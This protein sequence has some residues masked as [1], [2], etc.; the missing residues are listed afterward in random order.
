[1]G[2]RSGRRFRPIHE[3]ASSKRTEIT[4]LREKAEHEK[5][6]DPKDP[7][8]AA[9]VLLRYQSNNP[10]YLDF[11]KRVEGVVTDALRDDLR[12]K[13][14]LNKEQALSLVTPVVVENKGLSTISRRW[15]TWGYGQPELVTITEAGRAL[16][17]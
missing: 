9:L 4:K 7:G 12:M 17:A 13:N 16:V 14:K 15:G 10:T 11:F 2:R 6:T 1:M 5:A 8:A 3:T